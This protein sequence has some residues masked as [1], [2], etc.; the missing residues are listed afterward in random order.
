MTDDSA[1][2]ALVQ[3]VLHCFLAALR[4]AILM[5]G[6]GLRQGIGFT[7]SREGREE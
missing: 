5:S 2:G 7:R 1:F 6:S 4:E 3:A